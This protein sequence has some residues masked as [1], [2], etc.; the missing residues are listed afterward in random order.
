MEALN[1]ILPFLG[2]LLVYYFS[3]YVLKESPASAKKEH[4]I[5]PKFNTD[6]RV[7]SPFTDVHFIELNDKLRPRYSTINQLMLHM[8][9]RLTGKP[10]IND[11]FTGYTVECNFVNKLENEFE[12]IPLCTGFLK[13]TYPKDNFTMEERENPQFSSYLEL[14]L[15]IDLWNYYCNKYPDALLCHAVVGANSVE[16]EHL[17]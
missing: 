14:L 13:R 4:D 7:V 17:R 15:K 12:G 3:G 9:F 10:Y 5:T 16:N 11:Y 2:G 8:D 1:F 6:I